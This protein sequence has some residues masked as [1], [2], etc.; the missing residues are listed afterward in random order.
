MSYIAIRRDALEE[1][2]SARLLQSTEFPDGLELAKAIQSRQPGKISTR[3]RMMS[4]KNGLFVYSNRPEETKFVIFDAGQ[5]E[6]FGPGDSLSVTLNYIQKSLRFAT[7]Y[8]QG[9]VLSPNEGISRDGA[10]GIVF[11][12][13]ISQQTEI[14]LVIDLSPDGERLSKRGKAGRYLLV[15]RAAEN[16]K[17]GTEEPTLGEFRRFLDDLDD[18]EATLNSAQPEVSNV[19][20]PA[21]SSTTLSEIDGKVDPHQAYETWLHLLTSDQADFVTSE[22][23]SPKR[24]DGPAGSGKT[25]SLSLS[26]IHTMIAAEKNDADCQAIFITHSEASRRSIETMLISMGGER[27]MSRDPIQR[28]LR[29]MTLQGY[30]AEILRTEISATELV[31]PDAFD[32]KQLQTMYVEEALKKVSSELPSFER[33]MSPAFR[34]YLEEEEESLKISMLQHEISVV[35]KGRSKENFDI[36]KRI[37]PLSTGLPISK[38]GDKG[39]VWRVYEFYRHQLEA[40]AQFDTDDVVLTA[41]SQLTTPIWRRRR[42]RFGFDAVFVD[43][44][45]LFNMNE[46]SVFHH[47]TKSDVRFPIAF[48]VDRTQ[49]IGDRGWV[50]D[51]DVSVLVP[52]GQDI[53]ASKTALRSIFRSSPDIVNLAF[54]ITS[55][56]ANLFTNFEDPLLKAHS[57]MSFEEEKKAETPSYR[58]YA[59]DDAMINSAFSLADE[60][61][62]SMGTS[63]GEIAIIAFTEELFAGLQREAASNGKP[64]E[65]LKQRNDHEIAKRA[66]TAGRFVLSLPDYVGGLEFDGVILVGVD[67][68]RVP[69]TFLSQRAESKAYMSYS[70]HNRLYVA[71]SRARYRVVMMGT[72]ERGAS[73]LLGAAFA[74]KALLKST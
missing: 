50:N 25:V 53:Q 37:P 65:L 58:E 35:I 57:N 18:V 51:I 67:E 39:F 15:F 56:G 40:G 20:I 63:R 4:T 8:W 9:I 45:H 42:V 41:L 60:M 74:S 14:R 48:A 7:K 11:P 32:A 29:V 73:P 1:I 59:T 5:C 55:S 71:I 68:G 34:A 6:G 12:F 44:T 28:W 47:L 19:G 46:L 21:L 17:N 31:D 3:I 2:I 13:P 30:C 54:T 22:L 23:A 38:D 24:V 69:P 36:Y 72:K 66:K 61:R 49:A 52:H 33:F 27:F 43:E 10:R 16:A 62:S 70:A 64:V 26:A